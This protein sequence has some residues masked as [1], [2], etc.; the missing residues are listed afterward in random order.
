MDLNLFNED[1]SSDIKSIIQGSDAEKFQKIANTLCVKRKGME[2]KLEQAGTNVT[3]AER[4]ELR[5]LITEM[6]TFGVG[7]IEYAKWLVVEAKEG[8]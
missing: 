1:S 7:E 4:L 3:D 6:R 5:D 8:R 2:E